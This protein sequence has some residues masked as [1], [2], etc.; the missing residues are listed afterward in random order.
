MIGEAGDAVEM[1]LS[2]G[3]DAAMTKFNRPKPPEPEEE[4]E[5]PEKK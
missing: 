1:I 4:P 2:Q 5:E 3:L